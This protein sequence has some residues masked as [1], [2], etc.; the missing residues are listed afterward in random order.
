MSSGPGR[1]DPKELN[2]RYVSGEA[3]SRL[4]HSKNCTAPLDVSVP[5]LGS[6]LQLVVSCQFSW[7][8]RAGSKALS[9]A[10]LYVLLRRAARQ[11]ARGFAL[12]SRSS[13]RLYT[14]SVTF[15]AVT[16]ALPSRLPLLKAP[17][18]VTSWTYR[19][20]AFPGTK[21]KF[22]HLLAAPER[23][24]AC[25]IG[26][27]GHPPRWLFITTWSVVLE[28]TV[29]VRSPIAVRPEQ[30]PILLLHNSYSVNAATPGACIATTTTSIAAATGTVMRISRVGY[31]PCAVQHARRGP[32]H[33]YIYGVRYEMPK[34]TNKQTNKQTTK[35]KH[36]TLCRSVTRA[37]PRQNHT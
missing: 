28:D 14:P 12:P 9:S 10:H 23:E 20:V 21:Q 13:V 36:N 15:F 35:Q 31:T 34:Q 1:V 26:E 22:C 5:S 27:C 37:A 30:Q 18:A 33:G 25:M 2:T 17:G 29:H 19:P 8:P 16:A 4:A 11:L 6:P 3:G 7:R 32:K 24:E